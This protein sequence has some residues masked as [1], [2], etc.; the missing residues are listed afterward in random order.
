MPSSAPPKMQAN[1]TNA[2][3]IELT[4]LSPLEYDFLNALPI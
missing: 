1:V 3:V 4:A 2:M